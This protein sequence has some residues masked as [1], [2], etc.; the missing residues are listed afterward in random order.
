MDWYVWVAVAAV[1]VV[2]TVGLVASKK[3]AAKYAAA[4]PKEP[5]ETRPEN[6]VRVYEAPGVNQKSD[7]PLGAV[8]S[9]VRGRVR[10]AGFGLLFIAVA[11]FGLLMLHGTDREFYFE[12]TPLNNLI[13]T[14]LLLG[15]VA[16]GLQLI[17]YAT[18]SV[19]LRRL[20]FELRS[21]LGSR[22]SYAYRDS[23][24]HL[25]RTIEHKNQSDG[26]RPIMAKAGNYNYLWVCQ[27]LVT[28]RP[29][30]IV[31]KSSRYSRLKSKM[32]KLLDGLSWR[33][34]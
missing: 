17:Y 33:E 13:G 7:H 21:I 19:R 10:F 27:V 31:L 32:D 1:A 20:G 9:V 11:L 18:C 4:P 30:P 5:E 16:W 26:Y 22:G 24:F 28:G 23:Q 34:E 3:A 12:R 6:A 14:V 2:F 15:A 8:Q 29:K 25:A